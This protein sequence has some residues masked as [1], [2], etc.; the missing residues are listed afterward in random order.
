MKEIVKKEIPHLILID[1]EKMEV[2]LDIP[3]EQYNLDYS[4]AVKGIF[5]NQPALL[6]QRMLVLE[7]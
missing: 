6:F 4:R 1:L 2:K 3:V 7:S 5:D